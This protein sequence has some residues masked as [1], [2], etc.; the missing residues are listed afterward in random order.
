MKGLIEEGKELM[1][2]DADPSVM[3]AGLISSAQRVEHYEI[4]AYGT[5]RVWAATLGF[6]EAVEL[7]QKTLEEEKAADQRLSRI[8]EASVNVEAE[9]EES[10][11]EP[12]RKKKSRKPA[13]RR[14]RRKT[15]SK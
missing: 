4:A 6:D 3:D 13:P 15:V 8:A 7:L 1:K 11:L 10:E 9:T 2:E 12:V 14:A 5:L